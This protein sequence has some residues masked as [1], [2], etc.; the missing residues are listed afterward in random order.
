MQ[1][2]TIIAQSGD[3]LRATRLIEKWRP[4]CW[5]C[6]GFYYPH[7]PPIR[8]TIPIMNYTHARP[9]AHR[10]RHRHRHRHTCCLTAERMVADVTPALQRF[11]TA[12]AHP[13]PVY[14]PPPSP[15]T[16]F[17]QQRLSPA[18]CRPAFRPQALGRHRTCPA[19]RECTRRR[20]RCCAR[21]RPTT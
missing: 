3:S 15:R 11:T 2:I 21:R 18:R 4:L 12:T 17:N 14:P 8:D 6:K 7:L 9:H 5:V 19:A 1:L 16:S 20:R 13:Y 10:H